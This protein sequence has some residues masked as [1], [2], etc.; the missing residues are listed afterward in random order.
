VGSEDP[1]RN[2]SVTIRSC[3]ACGNEFP[4]SGRRTHC[5]DACR[6]SAHRRRHA[7]PRPVPPVLPAKGKKRDSTVYECNG[8]GARALG[9]QRCDEC[10][11]FMS[12]VGIGGLCLHCDEPLAVTELLGN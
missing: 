3:A 2:D 8:C 1:S 12:V 5:S 9:S 7:S 11:S 6:Q 4:A 10:H